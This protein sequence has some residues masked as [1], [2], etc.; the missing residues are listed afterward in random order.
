MP[1]RVFHSG[2]ELGI[3]TTDRS[4][5]PRVLVASGTARPARR[6]SCLVKA[7]RAA[8]LEEMS[9]RRMTWLWTHEAC[10]RVVEVAAM[11]VEKIAEEWEWHWAR[12]PAP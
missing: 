5:N 6:R 1:R 10:E 7:S 4:V 2:S 8:S 3:H 11:Q 12:R 9:S